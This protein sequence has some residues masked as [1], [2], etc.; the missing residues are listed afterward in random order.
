[1]PK[2]RMDDSACR[3]KCVVRLEHVGVCAVS[4]VLSYDFWFYIVGLM[5]FYEPGLGIQ[6][7]ELW[8]RTSER[9][10]LP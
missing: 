1:M 2:R 4:L 5:S 10:R 6:N 9:A 8:T 3:L 7:Y